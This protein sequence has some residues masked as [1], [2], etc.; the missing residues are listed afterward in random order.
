[1]RDYFVGTGL[2]SD[3]IGNVSIHAT[4]SGGGLASMVDVSKGHLDWYTSVITRKIDSVPVAESV[5][6]ATFNEDGKVVKE[7]VFWP[8]VPTDVVQDAL[9]LRAAVAG[10]DYFKQ[11]PS[12]PQ[13]GQVTIH[14]TI[15]MGATLAFAS[16]YQVRPGPGMSEAPCYDSGGAKINLSQIVAGAP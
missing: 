9:A 16:C 6:W 4:M 3:Q 10:G 13:D 11:A 1:V 2:P 8:P 14:H 5:A 12:V 7:S 15:G